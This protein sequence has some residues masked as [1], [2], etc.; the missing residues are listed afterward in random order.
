MVEMVVG[1]VYL[2]AQSYPR[3]L[4]RQKEGDTCLQIVIGPFEAIAI[5]M[6]H[7]NQKPLRPISYDL[8]CALLGEIAARVLKV[9]ITDLHE[10][11]FYAEV[12]LENPDGSVVSLDSRP[13]DAVAL[14]LRTGAPIYAAAAV[15]AEAGRP[16]SPEELP[17][18]LHL[19][20]ADPAEELP[21]VPLLSPAESLSHLELLKKRLNQAIAEEAYEEAARLRDQIA[22]LEQQAA[23]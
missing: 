4:L 22:G 15:L 2:N 8:A 13:S 7:N 17:N 11:T 16:W 20:A 6:A 1:G 14:A 10:G 12:H 23:T 5:S 18:A 21:Q 3:L 9:E 19:P